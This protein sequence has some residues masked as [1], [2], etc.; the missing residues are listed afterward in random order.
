M[1]AMNKAAERHKAQHW[2]GEKYNRPW[3]WKHFI[4]CWK[5]QSFEFLR[6]GKSVVAWTM[7]LQP[8]RYL[9]FNA[10]SMLH[11]MAKT[12]VEDVN[13]VIDFKKGRLSRWM[14]SDHLSPYMQGTVSGC[15]QRE[16][17]RDGRNYR[18]ESR[19][20]SCLWDV[21]AHIPGSKRGL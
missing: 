9:H 18:L 10:W 8:R 13:E 17:Q 20:L 21:G 5:G 4:W 6:D 16:M 12:D 11:Y 1:R 14:Y 2:Y 15:R 7:S 19:C 3:K